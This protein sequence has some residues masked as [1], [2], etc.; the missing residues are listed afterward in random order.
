MQTKEKENIFK[1]FKKKQ[2]TTM[3]KKMEH[4]SL[5][6]TQWCKIICKHF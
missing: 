5:R 2:K 1:S 3:G 6:S 4:D